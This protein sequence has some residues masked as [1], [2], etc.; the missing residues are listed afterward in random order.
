MELSAQLRELI[1]HAPE[2]RARALEIESEILQLPNPWERSTR[3]HEL[4]QLSESLFLDRKHALRQYQRAWKATGRNYDALARARSM[5]FRELTRPDMVA[6]LAQLEHEHT[7]EPACRAIAGRAWVDAGKP[8][9]GIELLRA[10]IAHDP[11]D[12]ASRDA[13][14]VAELFPGTAEEEVAQLRAEAK[15]ADAPIAA[16]WYLQAA[17]ILRLQRDETACE[18]M[19]RHAIDL[20][21]S[22]ESATLLLAS[23]LEAA[24]DWEAFATLYEKHAEATESDYDRVDIYRRAGAALVIRFKQQARGAALLERSLTVA[25]QAGLP[26]IPGHLAM[27]STLL[28]TRQ[29]GDLSDVLQLAEHALDGELSTDERLFISA[30]AVRVA[31]IAL[32]E[33]DAETRHLDTIR[34]ILPDHSLLE[35]LEETRREIDEPTPRPEES[36]K[37]EAEAQ[38]A[39]ELERA[40]ENAAR[41][42]ARTVESARRKAQEEAGSEIE[43]ARQKAR[44]EA[45]RELEAG[46]R[47]AE[48]A[49]QRELERALARVQEDTQRELSKTRLELEKKATVE[50]ENARREALDEARSEVRELGRLEAEEQARRE[51]EIARDAEE[52]ARNELEE[53]L[54]LGAEEEMQRQLEK[55]R[56]EA[57]DQ[58]RQLVEHA[59]RDAQQ[60]ARREIAEAGTEA[61][62]QVEALEAEVSRAREEAAREAERIRRVSKEELE[63]EVKRA[64][65]EAKDDIQR[66]GERAQREAEED[67]KREVERARREAREDLDRKIERAQR[68]AME[69]A[70]RKTEALQRELDQ[71][72]RE[73]Q[74]A[75]ALAD[76]EAEQGRRATHAVAARAKTKRKAERVVSSH[77]VEITYRVPVDV[78]LGSGDAP[79]TVVHAHT[80]DLSETGVFVESDQDVAQ[81]GP[82]S[83]TLSIPSED[84]W[85]V[86]DYEIAGVVVRVEPGG[87][88]V[89]LSDTPAGFREALAGLRSTGST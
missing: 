13:L 44:E 36:A 31:R 1:W 21:P 38:L 24:G 48:E 46:I 64:R 39:R 57:E 45:R 68:N 88:A 47:Q 76:R 7:D 26:E 74:A 49:A 9:R 15:N 84:G 71:A 87:F 75:S 40:R 69:D 28:A 73:T 30:L 27:L 37:S 43:A 89:E 18:E 59:K 86:D 2:W 54:R 78:T 3:L 61:T 77:A 35:E 72:K 66:A 62:A 51:V 58:T 85:G 32:G 53:D 41:E 6:Q 55:V 52:H 83:I 16:R 29:D 80:R 23:L 5:F 70:R 33:A 11:D 81:G 10:A 42:A 63:R 34:S 50:I 25:Y 17:R 79:R 82:V 22:S 4:A 12:D 14:A 60:A 67:I 20:D 56:R 19:L 8:E 65:S